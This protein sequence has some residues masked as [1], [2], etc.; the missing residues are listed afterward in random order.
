MKTEIYAAERKVEFAGG[1]F[2]HA[3][4]ADSHTGAM[5]EHKMMVRMPRAILEE[6][7]PSTFMVSLLRPNVGIGEAHDRR[8]LD[9]FDFIITISGTFCTDGCQTTSGMPHP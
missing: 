3:R 8:R 2:G 5:E 7:C 4:T 1:N 6:P 9:D